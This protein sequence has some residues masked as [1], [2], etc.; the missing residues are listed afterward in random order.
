MLIASLMAASKHP[1][2]TPME[3]MAGRKLLPT[4]RKEAMIVHILHLE[5]L[6]VATDPHLR[7]PIVATKVNPTVDNHRL[8]GTLTVRHQGTPTV[9]MDMEAHP[10]TSP[11]TI[12]A[13]RTAIAET[14]LLRTATPTTTRTVTTDRLRLLHTQAKATVR[15][16]RTAIEELRLLLLTDRPAM[17]RTDPDTVRTAMDS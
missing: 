4:T 7:T 15:T 8:Q 12:I 5:T 10:T 17:V 6:T 1:L 16:V 14:R 3:T 9:A 13:D 11:P 2:T